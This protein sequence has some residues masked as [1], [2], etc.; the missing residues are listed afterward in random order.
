MP[1][2]GGDIVRQSRRSCETPMARAAKPHV[3]ARG[4]HNFGHTQHGVEIRKVVPACA[5]GRIVREPLTGSQIAELV[6]PRRQAQHQ[7][8]LV[9][10]RLTHG[11]MGMLPVAEVANNVHGPRCGV[12]EL[13][14]CLSG[15]IDLNH[16]PK[17]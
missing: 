2:G 5:E 16:V 11:K 17:T 12:A 1:Q 8:P 15:S 14:G 4:R 3:P 10:A 7:D 13:K 6:R 9:V